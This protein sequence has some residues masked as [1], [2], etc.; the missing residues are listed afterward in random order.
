QRRSQDAVALEER[1][2]R[3]GG[4]RQKADRDARKREQMSEKQP[5]PPSLPARL[6][7]LLATPGRALG[8]MEAR[9]GGGVRDAAW[10]VLF[11][12]ICFR[13]QDQTRAL[14]GLSQVGVAPLLAVFSQEVREAVTVALGA[15]LT[16]TL[17]AGRGRRDPSIDI[18]LGAACYVPFFA[19][20]S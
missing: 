2:G 4:R 10:L 20:R 9:G 7:A 3:S 15:G 5:R 12:V 17:L 14:L 8:A 1:P 11:G 18:E 16:L 19:A 6:G 13:L